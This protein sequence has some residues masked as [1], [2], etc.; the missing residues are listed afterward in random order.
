MVSAINTMIKILSFIVLIVLRVFCMMCFVEGHQRH[1]CCNIGNDVK[2]LKM[3]L[4]D[5][6]NDVLG[7]YKNTRKGKII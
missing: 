4:K 1:K 7:R 2:T 5:D 6:V 3:K